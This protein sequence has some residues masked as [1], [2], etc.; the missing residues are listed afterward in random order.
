MPYNHVETVE[1]LTNPDIPEQSRCTPDLRREGKDF[2]KGASLRARRLSG[3]PRPIAAQIAQPAH[4]APFGRRETRQ[5]P[6]WIEIGIVSPVFQRHCR[7]GPAC[8]GEEISA[9]AVTS[10]PVLVVSKSSGTQFHDEPVIQRLEDVV[11]SHST[12]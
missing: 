11:P 2:R 1:T 4:P 3:D 6:M 10:M 9:V 5:G 7:G 12:H 8:H